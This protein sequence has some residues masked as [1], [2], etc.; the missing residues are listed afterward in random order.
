MLFMIQVSLHSKRGL[1]GPFYYAI[2]ENV[3]CFNDLFAVLGH[4][5][6]DYTQL[7]LTG[8]HL[9]SDVSD[10]IFVIVPLLNVLR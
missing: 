9:P 6:S 1:L 3:G 7:Y 8:L 4:N 2:R 5:V 10:V